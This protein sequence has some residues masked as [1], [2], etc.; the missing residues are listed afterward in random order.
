MGNNLTPYSIGIR[1]EN[2]Y[3]LTPHFIFIERD[4]IDNDE[5]LNTNKNSVDPYDYHVSRCG[6]LSFQRICKYKIH[7]N[8]DT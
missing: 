2:V 3:F 4:K 5:L 1:K 8:Y 6:K 7:S